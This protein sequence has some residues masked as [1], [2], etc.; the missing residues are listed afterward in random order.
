MLTGRLPS[1]STTDVDVGQTKPGVSM[2]GQWDF[3]GVRVMDFSHPRVW[4][5]KES[6]P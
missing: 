3:A 6:N 2:G 5:W 1:V 4:R